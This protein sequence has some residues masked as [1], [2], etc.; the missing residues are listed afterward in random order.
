MELD[1]PR[2]FDAFLKRLTVPGEGQENR[3]RAVRRIMSVILLCALLLIIY[4][5][6][7]LDQALD[8]LS[9]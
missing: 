8:M 3:Q 2:G 9:S 7:S 5:L 6:W 4:L 1:Q